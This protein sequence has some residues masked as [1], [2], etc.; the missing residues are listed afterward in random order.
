MPALSLAVAGVRDQADR[1]QLAEVVAGR[2]GVGAEPVSEVGG[3]GGTVQPQRG[4]EAGAQR[5]GEHPDCFG[6][7]L[8]VFGH[9]CTIPVHRLF[10]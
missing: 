3:R 8:D 10:A 4:E 1:L 6:V 2:A 5:V 9:A 7:E